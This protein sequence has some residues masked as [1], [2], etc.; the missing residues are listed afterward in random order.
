VAF[1]IPNL[2]DDMHDGTITQGDQ[3][4]ATNLSGYVT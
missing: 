3:W 4:L 1:V 2:D